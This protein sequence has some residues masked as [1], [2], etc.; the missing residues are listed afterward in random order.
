MPFCQGCQKLWLCGKGLMKHEQKTPRN[1]PL[2]LFKI[3]C[4]KEKMPFSSNLTNSK[5]KSE[6]LN[7]IHRE[8]KL[9]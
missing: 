5:R 1:L 3:L 9:V 4:E 2:K 8:K 7:K 6:K